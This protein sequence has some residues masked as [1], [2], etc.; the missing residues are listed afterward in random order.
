MSIDFFILLS[1]TATGLLAYNC[2]KLAC[3]NVF[4]EIMEKTLTFLASPFY[5]QGFL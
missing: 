2:V 1:L 5:F 4:D 3:K